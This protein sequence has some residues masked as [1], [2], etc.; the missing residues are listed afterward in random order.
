MSNIVSVVDTKK[1]LLSNALPA[2][3]ESSLDAYFNKIYCLPIL[4][5]EEE[6]SLAERY[7]ATQDLSAAHQLVLSHLRYVAKNCQAI[8]GLWFGPI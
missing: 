2:L 1:S 5:P 4:T 7:Q 3:T 6:L 8:H